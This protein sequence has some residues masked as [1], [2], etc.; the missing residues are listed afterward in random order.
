MLH[1][2]ANEGEGYTR[3]AKIHAADDDHAAEPEM[4]WGRSSD[5]PGPR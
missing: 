1:Q 4:K 5:G 2:Y 3:V